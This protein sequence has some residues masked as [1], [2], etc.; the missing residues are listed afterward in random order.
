MHI[1][2]LI[3]YQPHSL[4]LRHQRPVANV[5]RLQQI[6]ATQTHATLEYRSFHNE[7]SKPHGN[8]LRLTFLASYLETLGFVHAFADH[9]LDFRIHR[10]SR[11]AN[12]YLQLHRLVQPDTVRQFFQGQAHFADCQADTGNRHVDRARGT[13]IEIEHWQ[14]GLL[15]GCRLRS[16][17]FPLLGKLGADFPDFTSGFRIP[18]R[19][20][21][22]GENAEH[23]RQPRPLV[24]GLTHL[25]Q[26]FPH[27]ENHGAVAEAYL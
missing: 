1:A 7:R 8:I 13:E 12:F 23:S 20:R 18:G 25:P 22:I 16:L 15:S 3:G 2:Q 11:A 9:Q 5:I 10:R 6:C 24:P 26:H 27:R 14:L 17:S 19:C 4:A 21:T